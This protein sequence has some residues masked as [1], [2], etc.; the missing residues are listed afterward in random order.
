MASGQFIEKADI[1]MHYLQRG[2]G[3]PVLMLH[4]FPANSVPRGNS[5]LDQ[6]SRYFPDLR[7][8]S[9][10]AGHFFPE[11]DPGSTNRALIDFLKARI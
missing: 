9:V 5:F 8:R 2:T 3:D 6:F 7:A 4:G 1:R 11:E 10:N